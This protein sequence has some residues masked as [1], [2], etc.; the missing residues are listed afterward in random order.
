MLARQVLY[1][2]SPSNNRILLKKKKKRKKENEGFST[3]VN[4]NRNSKKIL[5]ITQMVQ[6]MNNETAN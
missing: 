5:K 3:K 6:Y 4:K 2:L 1:C